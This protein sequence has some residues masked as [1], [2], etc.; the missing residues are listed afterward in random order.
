[1]WARKMRLLHLS[2]TLL[3]SS[4]S[5]L[6]QLEEPEDSWVALIVGG[7]WEGGDNAEDPILPVLKSFKK[8]VDFFCIF[9]LQ[10]V[11][12]FGCSGAETIAMPDY[13]SSAY[14]SAGTF[15][16]QGEDRVISCGGFTCDSPGENCQE[17]AGE[18]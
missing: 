7:Y 10:S 16:F 17:Q 5:S 1:M 15:V 3:L 8:F 4:S 13:P 11:E 18:K 14:L 2:L 12:L 9:Y 6:A